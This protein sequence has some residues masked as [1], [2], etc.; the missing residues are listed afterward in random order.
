M[1]SSEVGFS[2]NQSEKVII[3]RGGQIKQNLKFWNEITY[4]RVILDYVSRVKIDF[5]SNP[6]NQLCYPKEILYSIAEREAV[7]VEIKLYGSKGTIEEVKSTE[8]EFTS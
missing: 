6:P 5:N 8:G 4:D 1:L 7:S 3:F 2:L